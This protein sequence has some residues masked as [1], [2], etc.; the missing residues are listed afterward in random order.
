MSG[1]QPGEI[2]DIAIKGV[3]IGTPAAPGNQVIGVVIEDETGMRFAM[4]PQAAI[5]RVAPAD[6]PPCYKDVWLTDIGPMLLSYQERF[7]QADG[8]D[9]G[10]YE[11]VLAQHGPLTL[12]YREGADQPPAEDAP[13]EEIARTLARVH[14][15]RAA[16]Y[17]L[18]EQLREGA[19]RTANGLLAAYQI[20]PRE[21]QGGEG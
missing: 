5:T 11:F 7:V 18:S 3:R 10:G 12:V 9:M 19:R 1:F 15:P 8:K 13:V 4:P 14:N 21:Q 6:W 20:T 2:V 17:D 16:W